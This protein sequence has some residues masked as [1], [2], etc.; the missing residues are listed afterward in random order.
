MTRRSLWADATPSEIV[1]VIL[2][3]IYAGASLR[4]LALLRSSGDPAVREM[5]VALTAIAAAGSTLAPSVLD[6]IED[7]CGDANYGRFFSQLGTVVAAGQG[8]AVMLRSAYRRDEAGAAVKARRRRMLGTLVVMGVIFS[9]DRSVAAELQVPSDRLY[10]PLPTTYWLVFC[11]FMVQ[12]AGEVA[13]LALRSS[14]LSRKESVRVGLR[15]VATGALLLAGHYGQLGTA[16]AGRLVSRRLPG[17][18]RGVPAQAVIGFAAALIALGASLPG[19]I[20]RWRT[21]EQRLQDTRNRI[22]LRPVWR[23]LRQVHHETSRPVETIFSAPDIRLLRRVIGILDRLDRLAS[24]HDPQGRIPTATEEVGRQ[25][26]LGAEDVT[27]LQR[28]ALIRYAADYAVCSDSEQESGQDQGAAAPLAGAAAHPDFREEARRLL[29]VKAY[30]R[31]SS[32]SSLIAQ[33]VREAERHE[34]A[35]STVTVSHSSSNPAVQPSPAHN[36]DREQCTCLPSDSDSVGYLEYAIGR[37]EAGKVLA[38]ERSRCRVHG[39]A[40]L[41]N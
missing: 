5:G 17:P 36:S 14:R 32:P 40:A 39:E 1:K 2:P 6:G 9:R 37:S 38:E 29:L 30:L 12:T 21:T 13:Q 28:A 20:W 34:R 26:G 33:V 8:D 11:N 35:V 16:V 19:A 27:A 4:L 18:V 23:H 10:T 3:V 41:L 22:T 31:S 24:D 7:V 25:R 15:M